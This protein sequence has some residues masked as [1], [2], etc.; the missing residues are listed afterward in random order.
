MGI[1]KVDDSSKAFWTVSVTHFPF[2]E[3]QIGSVNY[4][5]DGNLVRPPGI[6]D[7]KLN[8]IQQQTN[9]ILDYISKN[10]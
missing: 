7:G 2:R 4:K 8:R 6:M 3:I 9:S 1:C 10:I 5:V